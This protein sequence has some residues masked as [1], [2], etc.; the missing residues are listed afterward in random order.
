VVRGDRVGLAWQWAFTGD[1]EF[2]TRL[3]LVLLLPFSVA[4]L[5]RAYTLRR[6]ECAAAAPHPPAVPATKIQAS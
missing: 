5:W 3:W 2:V 1:V 4:P 6:A